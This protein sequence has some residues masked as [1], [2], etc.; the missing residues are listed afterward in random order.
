METMIPPHVGMR[1]RTKN[2][3]KRSGEKRKNRP[4]RA[5]QKKRQIKREGAMLLSFSTLVLQS[6]T[7]FFI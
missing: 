6:S 3:L 5:Q 7:L 4:K 2:K 1:L